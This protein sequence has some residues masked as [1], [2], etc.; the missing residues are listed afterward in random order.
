MWRTAVSRGRFARL[1]PAHPLGGFLHLSEL[2]PARLLG[3]RNSPSSCCGEH[4]LRSMRGARSQGYGRTPGKL[5]ENSNRFPKFLDLVL[6]IPA[7][8]AKPDECLSNVGHSTVPPRVTTVRHCIT[9][10]VILPDLLLEKSELV[11]PC[12]RNGDWGIIISFFGNTRPTA[13]PSGGRSAD[14]PKRKKAPTARL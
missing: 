7:F 9:R 4:A 10:L 2:C 8:L 12:S 5:F 14:D 1:L 3:E 6:C 13:H 11:Q